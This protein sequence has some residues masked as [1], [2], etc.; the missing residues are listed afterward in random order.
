ML[1]PSH[2]HP[3]RQWRWRGYVLEVVLYMHIVIVCNENIKR[4]MVFPPLLKDNF[5]CL[6]LCLHTNVS[7]L[8]RRMRC[9]PS[10]C[11]HGSE[12]H[13]NLLPALL[14]SVTTSYFK[15]WLS[16][17]QHFAAIRSEWLLLNYDIF[18]LMAEVESPALL[19]FA[20][21]SHFVWCDY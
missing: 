9:L 18:V 11:L 13:S 5:D 3:G 4:K 15:C 16:L 1:Y 21:R 6:S 2:F 7:S 20:T 14:S 10:V 12:L 19:L 8:S 17:S